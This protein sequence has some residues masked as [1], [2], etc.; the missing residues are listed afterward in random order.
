[1]KGDVRD[2]YILALWEARCREGAAVKDAAAKTLLRKTLQRIVQQQLDPAGPSVVVSVRSRPA[3]LCRD[4][5]V[6]R[7]A[8]RIS[9]RGLRA[10]RYQGLV[11]AP[12]LR[13]YRR[14]YGKVRE[15]KNERDS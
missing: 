12:M 14:W 6:V 1:V 7:V 11:V 2:L 13:H 9:Q 3:E 4:V 10:G 8:V 5:A 15:G